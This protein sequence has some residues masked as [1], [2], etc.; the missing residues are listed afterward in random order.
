MARKITDISVPIEND[1]AAGPRKLFFPA[2]KMR[3][4][5]GRLDARGAR[6]DA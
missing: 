6:I 5:A 3:E 4:P 2:L 1:A